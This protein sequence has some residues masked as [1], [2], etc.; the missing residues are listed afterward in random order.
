MRA[1][2]IDGVLRADRLLPLHVPP[3]QPLTIA[4]LDAGL[5][6]TDGLV[7]QLVGQGLAS[8][9]PK[10]LGVCPR[11][12]QT[13]QPPQWGSQQSLDTPPNLDRSRDL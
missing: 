12:S 4:R 13:T 9:G 10:D 8:V 5:P 1:Q 11:R 2:G 3:G 7:E 6:L